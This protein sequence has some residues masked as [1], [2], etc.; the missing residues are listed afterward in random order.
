MAMKGDPTTLEEAKARTYGP[1]YR[2][3]AYDPSRCCEQV[4]RPRA[5]GSVQCS[6]KPGYGPAGLYCKQ[7]DPATVAAKHAAMDAKIRAEW[8]Q[9]RAREKLYAAK[10][11]VID[12]A[13][14]ATYQRGTWD[15]VADA[16]GAMERAQ[17]EEWR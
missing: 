17:K 11:A 3:V 15:A 2:A 5:W 6:R 9:G 16:V 4:W 12:A 7:H 10:Q 14:A 13:V 1:T 8:N